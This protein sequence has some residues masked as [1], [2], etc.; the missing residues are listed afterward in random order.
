MLVFA[1][2]WETDNT[3]TPQISKDD[4]EKKTIAAL[5]SLST[6]DKEFTYLKNITLSPSNLATTKVTKGLHQE[7]GNQIIPDSHITLEIPDWPRPKRFHMY[8]W[9]VQ[10]KAGKGWYPYRLTHIEDNAR[11]SVDLT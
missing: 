11:K 3:S 9:Y 2:G 6:T 1:D 5:S 7:E 4:I 10:K 8:F